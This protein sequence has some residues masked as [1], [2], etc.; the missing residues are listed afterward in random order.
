MALPS[1]AIRYQMEPIRTLAFG[2]IG[3]G[4]AGIGTIINNPVRQFI[5]QN[6]TDV[7]LMFSFNGVDDHFVLAAGANFINDVTSNKTHTQG[8]TVA[9]GIRLYVKQITAAPTTGEVYF[10]VMYGAD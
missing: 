6:F 5:I 7:N 9:Q 3:A 10:S 8:Y 2:S 1:L 4:Y